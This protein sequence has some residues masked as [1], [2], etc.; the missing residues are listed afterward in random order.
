MFERSLY[1]RPV[2]LIDY[3]SPLLLASSTR[4]SFCNPLVT[5]AFWTNAVIAGVFRSPSLVLAFIYRV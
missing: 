1:S 3:Q 2:V 4:E 5:S